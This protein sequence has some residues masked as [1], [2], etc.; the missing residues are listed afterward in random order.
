MSNPKEDRVDRMLAQWGRERP[1]LD[2]TALAIVLRILILGGTLAERL[3]S[4]LA[5]LDLA[6]FEFDVLSALRRTGKRGGMSPGELCEAAQLT[7]GAMTHRLK[8]LEAR[9]FV[10]RTV[11]PEDGRGRFVLLTQ[12]GRKIADRAIEA[13]MQEARDSIAHL[14]EPSQRELRALLRRLCLGLPHP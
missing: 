12:A 8:R 3:K 6:P 9:G 7:T 4:A 13:R 11:D 1:D 10:Q 5:P 2:P 14:S